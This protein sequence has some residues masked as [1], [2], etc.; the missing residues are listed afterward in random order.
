MN[1]QSNIGYH[2]EKVL[3]LLVQDS[4]RAGL[5]ETPQRVAKALKEMTA[6]YAMDPVKTLKCF[7]DG[8]EGVDEMVVVSGVPFHS[9]CEHHMLP[10]SGTADIGY[11]PNG[12]VV[13]LS[14]LPRVFHIYAKRL[15]VQERLVNQVADLLKEHLSPDV[16][17][18]A[19]ATHLCM[20]CRGVALQ[21][22]TTTT[23]ACRGAFK[24]QPET[25]AEF[26]DA[27]R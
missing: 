22:V 3:E 7:Q 14:K 16:A 4:N 6:G 5:A 17:V 23:T 1:T 20:E 15:Q 18:R 2:I 25:R 21:G 9:L 19:R 12:R 26:L 24:D 27:C 10:F 13:G 11:I 8:A